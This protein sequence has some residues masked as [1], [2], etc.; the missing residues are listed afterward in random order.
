MKKVLLSVIFITLFT[1]LKAQDFT[2]KVGFNF[3]FDNLEGSIPYA[4]TRTLIDVKITPEL[5]ITIDDKH[6]LMVGASLIQ[7]LG[8]SI[9]FGKRD[10]IVYYKFTS[11]KFN[12]VA[13]SFPRYHSMGNYPRSFFRNDFLFFDNNIE[14]VLAQYIPEKNNGF[15]EFYTDWYGQNQTLRLDE[16]SLVAS[17]EFNYFD[18]LLIV[19]GSALVN[20]YK[21]D[22]VLKDAYLY[23]RAL[24]NAYVATDLSSIFPQLDKF[25]IGFGT[26]SSM[27]N[28]RRKEIDSKWQNN[29]GWQLD[30]DVNWKGF[31]LKNEFYFGDP[32]LMYYEQY[33]DVIYCGSRFYQAKKYNFTEFYYQRAWDFLSI[34]GGLELH[35]T[36]KG[37][38][39]QQMI[40]LNFNLH[41]ILKGKKLINV[42]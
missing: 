24:Y 12:V 42:W 13:G 4:P 38:A 26:N 29:I 21:N 37:V 19:G 5:G 34:R 25:R 11:D 14:G 6:Q 35:T 41:Q 31:G 8:D 17:T 32:Q 10:Y 36:S 18:K 33:G 22:Y 20:H 9:L 40:S 39:I 16:F 2:Y 30:I 28:K 1:A 23:E 15:V 3:F 7:E 27:E